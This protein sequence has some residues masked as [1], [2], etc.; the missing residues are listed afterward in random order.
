[1]TRAVRL[2]QQQLVAEC[3][4]DLDPAADSLLAK[5]A[6]LHRRGPALGPGSVIDFGWAPLR[7]ESGADGA[8][9]VCEPDVLGDL[10]YFVPGASVTLRILDDQARVIRSLGVAPEATRF[11]E[12]VS[13]ADRA[14]AETAVYLDRSAAHRDG[15]S[16]WYAWPGGDEEEPGEVRQILAGKLV[17]LRPCWMRALALPLQ[18]GARFVDDRLVAVIDRECREISLAEGQPRA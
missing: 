2:G 16:G 1:M 8:W 15:H 3:P 13:V 10:R 4:S 11:N 5:L 18:Y 7:I 17:L 12:L 9:A 6:E 14:L